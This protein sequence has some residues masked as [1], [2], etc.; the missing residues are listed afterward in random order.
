[1]NNIMMNHI[2][3]R[4]IIRR[5][6]FLTPCVFLSGGGGGGEEGRRTKRQRFGLDL[7]IFGGKC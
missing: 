7:D 2:V 5:Y 4:E 6:W 3:Q 1:M